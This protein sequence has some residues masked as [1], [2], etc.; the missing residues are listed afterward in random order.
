[1]AEREYTIVAP[2]GRELTIIGPDNAS[3][4]QL[5]AAAESAFAKAPKAQSET[6]PKTSLLDDAKQAAGNVVAGAVRGAGSIGSTI[7]LPADMINDA[8]AGKGLSLESNRQRRADIDAGLRLAGADPDSTL[9]QG[10][11]LAGEIAGTA[12]V[13]GVVAKGAQAVGAAPSLVNAIA[14][15]GMRT[16][17]PQSLARNMLTRMA[18]G[19]ISG[20]ASAGLVDPEL[21]PSGAAVGG[22]LPPVL[23]ATGYVARSVGN[24]LRGPTIPGAVQ[25]GVQNAKSVGYVIPPTQA[26]PTFANRVIEGIAGKA[27][28]AQ[29]ASARN[30]EV[31]NELVKRAIGA[32]DLSPQGLQAVRSAANAEYDRLAQ[33]GSFVPDQKFVDSLRASAGS[34][35][36]P[37]ITNKEVDELV[38]VLAQQGSLDAQQTI[39]SIK[40]LR[41]DGSANRIAQDPTKKALGKAQMNIAKALEDLV[42]RNLAATGQQDLL[43]GYRN[44]RQTLAKVYDVEKAVNQ[45]TGNVDANK[46]AALLKKGRPLSGELKTVAEF[47]QQFPKAAQSVEKM[48]SLPQFSPLDFGALGTLSAVTSNPLLMAGVAARPAM[49]SLALSG[50][51]QNSLGTQASQNKLATLLANPEVQQ[52]IYRTAPVVISR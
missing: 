8:L 7:L 47:A 49:R 31:T 13:P 41:F 33:V 28:T 45:A 14:T 27:S 30:Q 18:G 1:M 26:N 29:N 34:K 17:A 16:G 2:D 5:R 3:K 12:G 38:D 46:L 35:A 36:L 4:D 6:K 10:G 37:G 42:D 48:G 43:S 11:K 25:T 32:S 24:T 20:G 51:I 44:A 39:E 22:A 50:A 15:S 21:A 23:G 52:Q 40:R 9:Y 19:A